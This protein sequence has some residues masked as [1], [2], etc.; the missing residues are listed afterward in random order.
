MT[1]EEFLD[2]KN[3]KVRVVDLARRL[4]KSKQNVDITLR[5]DINHVVVRTAK[6]YAQALGVRKKLAL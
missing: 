6:D 5:K 2:F 1:L 3:S 4:G